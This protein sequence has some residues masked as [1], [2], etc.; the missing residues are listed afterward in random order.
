MIDAGHTFHTFHELILMPT[1]TESKRFDIE[2]GVTVP[3]CA[4][5][6][7]YRLDELCCPLL[8]WL[9]PDPWDELRD[10]RDA[11]RDLFWDCTPPVGSAQRWLPT[12]GGG[13]GVCYFF[14]S[15]F[16]HNTIAQDLCVQLCTLKRIHVPRCK[17][18]WQESD[19]V[20]C[21]V[22]ECTS[23]HVHACVSVDDGGSR[24]SVERLKL[25][26]WLFFWKLKVGAT[27]RHVVSG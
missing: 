2:C 5:G 20:W 9:W 13:G 16:Q 4:W 8:L 1:R 27:H 18:S 10:A 14:N 26:L 17:R 11:G 21:N 3:A 7:M 12:M 25:F 23:K 24:S 6:L 15:Q 22:Q 19:P